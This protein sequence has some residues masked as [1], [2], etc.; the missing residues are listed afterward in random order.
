M[1]ELSVISDFTSIASN[2][3]S[4]VTQI[5]ARN[6]TR[7]LRKAAAKLNYAAQTVVKTG[8]F[9]QAMHLQGGDCQRVNLLVDAYVQVAYN[10]ILSTMR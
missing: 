8:Q 3:S 4:V 2:V 1:N 5:E 6:D 9:A 10:D 7:T